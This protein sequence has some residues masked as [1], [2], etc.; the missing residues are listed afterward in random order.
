MS[1]G[2]SSAHSG[3]CSSSGEER[4]QQKPILANTPTNVSHKNYASIKPDSSYIKEPES[5]IS[6]NNEMVMC[7]NEE[8]N[9]PYL[10]TIE[11][12]D[13]QH[14]EVNP[15]AY[16]EPAEI[17][18][19]RRPPTPVFSRPQTPRS[20]ASRPQTPRQVPTP[21][22]PTPRSRPNTPQKSAPRV[23]TPT[24]Q[25]RPSTPS[26]QVN[27]DDLIAV[28]TNKKKQY[29]RLKKELDL[30][31]QAVLELFESLRDLRPKLP[32]EQPVAVEGEL[33]VFNVADWAPEEVTQL[34]KDAA[35]SSYNEGTIELIN[36]AAIDEHA[37]GEVETK[38]LNIPGYFAELCLQAF[39]ARQEL[40]DWIK[41]LVEKK[42]IVNEEAMERI[43]IYNNQGLHLCETL[44]ELKSKADEAVNTVTLLLKRAS[45]ERSTL[46]TVGESLVREVARLRQDLESRSVVVE[47]IHEPRVDPEMNKALEDLRSELEEERIAK[48][49]M[50]E[51]LANSETQL[52]QMRLRI[53]KMDRQLREADASIIS[54]TETVKSSEDKIRQKEVHFEAR[55]RKLKETLKTGEVA[56]NHLAQQRDALQIEV[57]QLKDQIQAMMVQHKS[58]VQELNQRIKDLTFTLEENK[59]TTQTLLEENQNLQSLLTESKQYAEE[60]K[61]KVTDLEN[62][63]PNPDLPTER[64][65][66][67]WAELQATKDTL[68]MTEDE[69]T[70]CKREKIRFL[71]SLSKIAESDDKIGLQQKLSAELLNKEEILS[72]MQT[73]I[74]DLTKNIKLNEQKVIQYEQFVRDIQA[75]NRAVANCKEAPNGISY[76]DLQQEI[77]NLKMSLLDA[78][79]RNDELSE[80]LA[81]KEQQLEHQDKTSRAQTKVIKVR[82]ELINLLKNKETEQSRELAGLQQDLEHRMRIVDEV[83]KQIAEKADEIQEL[84]STL[85][86]KQQ[87]IHRLE[88]IVLALE[89]QQRRAQA[90]RTRHE[91]KIAALE[92]ELAAGGIRK[93]RFKYYPPDFDPSK[94]PRMKLAKNRQYTVRLMAPFNMRCATCGEYIYKGKKFNARKE[95]VENEDYL[96]IRIYRFYIKCTRCLQE[97][98]FKTDPKNTDYEIEAGATRNFMALKLAEEQAKKEEDEQKEEEAN[99]PMKLLEY[100]TEQSKQEIERLE[101][102]EELKELNRRQRTVDYEGML[103]Q[104]QGETAEERRAREEREDDDFIKSVKFNSSLKHKIVTE[105]I[106]EEC[107]EDGPRTKNIKIDEPSARVTDH[108]KNEAWKRSLG[109]TRKPLTNLVKTKRA[110]GTSSDRTLTDKKDKEPSAKA[111]G[112]ALLA[113][114][115]GSD[116]D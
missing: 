76:E 14:M 29:H 54:L 20:S 48:T 100:R 114:Y 116:S 64:E 19:K 88:K 22:V 44:R 112:L 34:C 3:V 82:E 94:I 59:I 89:E 101:S 21:R 81:Q 72:K 9:E 61:T 85:E 62:S 113:S 49:A 42:E 39:T 8:V 96:G 106:I 36:T 2:H 56:S 107:E 92:H 110:D 104:Y 27:S 35:A 79:H 6:E 37:L 69:I 52:R 7:S 25:P 87:Q 45:N 26:S 83:N 1:P 67:L 28:Y 66:D 13:I 16:V 30:K 109:V 24:P 18:S 115:S 68:R 99:N 91:E 40:I 57:N 111:T 50:K 78:V 90:Q 74:R 32:G 12:L 65:M 105:E 93:E 75:H 97:I 17:E 46:V 31:Q 53:S 71:E 63:K 73:Q 102:L 60:L 33:V 5:V 108:K 103:K 70:A 77:M 23:K 43:S 4:L 38:V 95:D 41:D 10:N 11:T 55:A 51:K 86:N 58:D 80:I 98:S 47:E 84:F 15:G